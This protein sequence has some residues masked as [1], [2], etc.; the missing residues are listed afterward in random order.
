MGRLFQNV[1]HDI[2]FGKSVMLS[3]KS[4]DDIFQEGHKARIYQDI[5]VF[6]ST[7]PENKEFKLRELSRYLLYNNNELRD[8]YIVSK[9]NESGRIDNI[10]GRVQ[11]NVNHL[12]DM[13]I[14]VKVGEVK[15]EKG[16]GLVP[17][18]RFTPFGYML[19][20]ILQS[21]RPDI[22][23]QDKLYALFRDI[24]APLEA[25]SWATFTMNWIKK[26][27]E[28][29]HF[30]HYISIYKKVIDS[31]SIWNI[32]K[33]NL[34]L[35]DTVNLRFFYSPINRHVFVNIWQEVIEELDPEVRKLVLYEVKLSLDSV[36]GTI[37]QT[38]EYEKRRFALIGDVETIVLEGYCNKCKRPAV[39]QMKIVEYYKSHAHVS[40]VATICP[41]C[42]SLDTT[43]Q[44]PQ[45][46]N[47]SKKLYKINYYSIDY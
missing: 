17:I 23:V 4:I 29:G 45:L 25:L 43:L 27:Y 19:S 1:M 18:F 47:I 13:L 32:R 33:F 44:L 46:W 30:S 14:I 35:L 3:V 26:V 8:H 39:T 40:L 16:T 41:L 11:R 9:L 12:V 42:N 31:G 10:T 6:G 15:E 21:D 5:L 37:A 20:L 24:L 22:N 36:M 2:Y 7:I 34:L 38:S 28:K